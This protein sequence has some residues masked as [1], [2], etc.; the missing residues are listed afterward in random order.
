MTLKLIAIRQG[1]HLFALPFNQKAKDVCKA[2]GQS[3]LTC[4][5]CKKLELQ[6]NTIQIVKGDLT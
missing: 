2:A 3:F 1:A 5:Q 6:G 4:E